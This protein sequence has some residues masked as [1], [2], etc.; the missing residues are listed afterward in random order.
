MKADVGDSPAKREFPAKSPHAAYAH[1]SADARRSSMSFYSKCPGCGNQHH[2][3]FP[4]CEHCG[5]YVR[6]NLSDV[7]LVNKEFRPTKRAA[8]SLQ[9]GAK[10]ARRRDRKAKVS[11]PAKSR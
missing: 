8:D 5:G 6:L 11:R 2:A 4:Y 3:S 1:R 10:S 7:V 9:V